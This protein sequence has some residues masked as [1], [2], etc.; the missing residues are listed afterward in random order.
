MEYG[1]EEAVYFR[2]HL[3]GIADLD[4]M[5]FIEQFVKKARY[6]LLIVM[7]MDFQNANGHWN[8]WFLHIKV[9]YGRTKS[10][11]LSLAGRI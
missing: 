2:D 6:V 8:K 4:D 11:G 10:R 3:R 9:S 7:G 5:E 1:E